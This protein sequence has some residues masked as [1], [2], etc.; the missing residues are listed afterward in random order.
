MLKDSIEKSTTKENM[1][2]FAGEHLICNF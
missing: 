1:L 2:K